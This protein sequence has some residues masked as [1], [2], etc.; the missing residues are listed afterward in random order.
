MCLHMASIHVEMHQDLLKYCSNLRSLNLQTQV[1]YVF[2]TCHDFLNDYT[3]NVDK[4]L[5]VCKLITEIQR[6]VNSSPFL[7]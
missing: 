7:C 5:C 4:F 6:G 3:V 1:R 2:E